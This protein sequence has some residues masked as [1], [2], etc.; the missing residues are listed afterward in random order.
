MLQRLSGECQSPRAEELVT[1]Q[2]LVAIRIIG[3]CISEALDSGGEMKT[4]AYRSTAEQTDT[5]MTAS[6]RARRIMT[7]QRVPK[8]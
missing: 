7:E 4:S 1:S 3:L 8:T 6:S 2:H 5:S